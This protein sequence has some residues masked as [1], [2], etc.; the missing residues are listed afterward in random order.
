MVY[1]VTMKHAAGKVSHDHIRNVIRRA[2]PAGEPI[3]F[4]Y[5]GER[6]QYSC[7]DATAMV[8]FDSE[9]IVI[10]PGTPGLVAMSR[11][12]Y[13][14]VIPGILL[15]RMNKKKNA[16]AMGVA[17]IACVAGLDAQP[18][19]ANEDMFDHISD[20]QWGTIRQSMGIGDEYSINDLLSDEATSE[21]GEGGPMTGFFQ[22]VPD[23]YW[24][25]PK[26]WSGEV[27]EYDVEWLNYPPHSVQFFIRGGSEEDWVMS[28]GH[29]RGQ[30]PPVD[31]VTY[32]EL[33]TS[34]EVNTDIRYPAW[35]LPTMAILGTL[36]VIML[37][38]VI[39][40][41]IEENGLW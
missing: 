23:E 26:S 18:T 7:G 8:E 9:E 36:D 25:P 24:L 2:H 22:Q 15:D 41:A 5:D 12:G 33:I 28:G 29:L 38:M 27:D 11:I 30:P 37:G 35:F 34:I 14:L 31:P 16:R 17:S 10:T 40:I 3:Q 1:Q 19:G 20:E 32:S 21:D 6:I 13:A 39:I 4:S